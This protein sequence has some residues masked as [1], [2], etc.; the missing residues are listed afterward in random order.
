MLPDYDR[1]PN[2]VWGHAGWPIPPDGE[3]ILIVNY[4]MATIEAAA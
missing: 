3:T 1:S 4:I 2:G